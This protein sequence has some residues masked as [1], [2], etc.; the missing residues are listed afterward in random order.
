M[1]QKELRTSLSRCWLIVSIIGLT[2]EWLLCNLLSVLVYFFLIGL[3]VLVEKPCWHT[4]VNRLL[5]R[6]SDGLFTSRN[7]KGEARNGTMGDLCILIRKAFHTFNLSRRSWTAIAIGSVQNNISNYCQMY[8][9]PHGQSTANKIRK[10][11]NRL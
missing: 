8:L 2:D 5:S 10:I 4:R 11:M 1:S 7:G 9:I 3:F 6:Y